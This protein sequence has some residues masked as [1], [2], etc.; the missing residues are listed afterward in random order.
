MTAMTNQKKN[1]KVLQAFA[2]TY[3]FINNNNDDDDDLRFQSDYKQRNP[4]LTPS[5]GCQI[6]HIWN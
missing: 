5:L 6:D 3:L 2:I 1:E 4:C